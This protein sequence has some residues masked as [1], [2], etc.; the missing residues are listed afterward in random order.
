MRI[1]TFLRI[2]WKEEWIW[3][4]WGYALPTSLDQPVV[5][6]FLGKT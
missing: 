1:I 3:W 6:G 4:C 2:P 5:M